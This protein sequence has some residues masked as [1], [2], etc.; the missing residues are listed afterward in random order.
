MPTEK[1]LEKIAEVARQRMQGV[2]VLEDIHD[3]HNAAAV[4]RTADAFGIQKVCFIFKKEK[5]SKKDS[6]ENKTQCAA[7]CKNK[8]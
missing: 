5:R 8:I 1:R 4:L 6:S 7:N 3:P 2:V